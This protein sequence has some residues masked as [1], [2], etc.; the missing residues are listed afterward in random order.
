MST[1]KGEG[2]NHPIF[3]SFVIPAKAGIHLR[4]CRA[5]QKVRSWIPDQAG[6]DEV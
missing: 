3:Q 4:H 5:N 1:P 6:D 2:L